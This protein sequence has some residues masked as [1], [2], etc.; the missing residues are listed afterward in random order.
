[1]QS[2]QWV[3][4]PLWST[5]NS[6][7]IAQRILLLTFSSWKKRTNRVSKLKETGSFSLQGT[8]WFDRARKGR[9]QQQE[10]A[11]H[12]PL[13]PRSCPRWRTTATGGGG[14][15]EGGWEE[16]GEEKGQWQLWARPTEKA[17]R[18]GRKVERKTGRRGSMLKEDTLCEAER[19]PLIGQFRLSP[20]SWISDHLVYFPSIQGPRIKCPRGFK[21]K[22]DHTVV[23]LDIF[24][25]M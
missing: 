19:R 22:S 20:I 13:T 11:S 14:E 21:T 16:N 10:G 25:Q 2:N 5:V 8:W 9:S 12:L 23:L 18:G 24:H 6:K 7:I 3:K 4:A 15:R 17:L 1:M